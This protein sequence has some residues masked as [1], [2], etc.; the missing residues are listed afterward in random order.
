MKSYIQPGHV[1]DFIA[2]GDVASGDVISS[3]GLIGIA[4]IDGVSGDT[5]P[6]NRVGV[7][8]LTKDTPLA[9]A[10]GDR[11]YWSGT[12]VTKT[13]SDT[14]L[15]VA[16]NAAG[17]SDTTVA[18][19]LDSSSAAAGGQAAAVADIATADGSDPATTQALA[20]AIKV[21]VNAILASLRAAGVMDT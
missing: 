19:L 14:P 21:K 9:I 1:F 12:E 8:S 20:N 17:S 6:C 13:T 11:V 2:A 10:Q 16:F 4:A 7:Y 5:I 15:G 3:G 18:V